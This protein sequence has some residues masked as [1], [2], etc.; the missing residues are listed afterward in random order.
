MLTI[1]IIAISH[2]REKVIKKG[3]LGDKS[4]GQG[5][6]KW[7]NL[8]YDTPYYFNRLVPISNNT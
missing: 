6:R 3:Y 1:R 8:H 2:Y 4:G 7:I 5:E